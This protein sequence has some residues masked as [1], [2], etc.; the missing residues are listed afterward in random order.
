MTTGIGI[1][2]FGFAWLIFL[3]LESNY[4]LMVALPMI[5]IGFGRALYLVPLPTSG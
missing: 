3:G 4:W 2:I 1:T 5:L